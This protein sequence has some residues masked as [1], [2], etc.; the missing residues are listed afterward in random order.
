MGA[1]G[2]NRQASEKS[3]STRHTTLVDAI[4]L[5][6]PRTVRSGRKLAAQLKISVCSVI[7]S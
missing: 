7:L 2:V 5:D 6:A 1:A 3:W 4:P